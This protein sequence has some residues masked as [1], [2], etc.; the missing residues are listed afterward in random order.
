VEQP[1]VPGQ[2]LLYTF[3]VFQKEQP[4]CTQ[5]LIG[6]PPPDLAKYVYAL[7]RAKG[8]MTSTKYAGVANPSNFI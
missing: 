7:G 6:Q 5:G 8:S 3:S 1:D 4:I 2:Q